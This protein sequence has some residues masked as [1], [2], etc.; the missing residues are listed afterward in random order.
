MHNK[1]EYIR[2]SVINWCNLRCLFCNPQ[3][4]KG[5]EDGDINTS[6]DIAKIIEFSVKMGTKKVRITGGEPL[7]RRDIYDI[8][9]VVST[10]SEIQDLSL[11]TNGILLKDRLSSLIDAGLM[12]INISLPSLFAERY[13]RITGGN[14]K[15]VMAGID[16]ALRFGLKIKINVVAYGKEVLNEIDSVID[17][18]SDKD[19]ELRFIEYMPVYSEIYDKNKFFPAAMIE[20]L[21]IEKY[22]FY[23][24]RNEK[25]IAKNIYSRAD[26][27]GRIGFIKAVTDQFCDICNKVR[28][29]C[30]GEMSPCLFSKKTVNILKIIKNYQFN[31]A[32]EIINEFIKAEYKSPDIASYLRGDNT[33]N[34][35]MFNIGG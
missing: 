12:R 3:G 28:I 32:R 30:Y 20:R 10:F 16:E 7:L 9:R 11:T 4:I 17:F 19:L 1:F 25:Q 18:I 29:D 31:E 23:V 5:G 26:I 34:T 27:K 6:D 13:N 8:I 15:F 35:R 33:C 14:I 24:T 2:L 21:L 22:N